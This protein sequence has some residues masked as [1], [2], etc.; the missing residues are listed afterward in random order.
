MDQL[1]G[2]FNSVELRSRIM[3]PAAQSTRGEQNRGHS[4]QQF[5]AKCCF[6]DGNFHT[7]RN[8]NWRDGIWLWVLCKLGV[9]ASLA[10]RY[11]RFLEQSAGHSLTTS[12]ACAASR[13]K[14]ALSTTE[15]SRMCHG[16]LI[17]GSACPN[18]SSA[19]ALMY[20]SRRLHRL[21]GYDANVA[22][23]CV[24]GPTIADTSAIQ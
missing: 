15:A 18:P 1:S 10:S 17:P 8:M 2:S 16:S 22:K 9:H 14:M 24:R 3:L 11:A 12:P 5:Q 4:C 13:T 20:R 21:A 7:N 23:A 19:E 6:T